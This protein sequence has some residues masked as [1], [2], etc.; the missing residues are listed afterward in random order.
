[1]LL[2]AHHR[3]ASAPFVLVSSLVLANDSCMVGQGVEGHE[4]TGERRFLAVEMMPNAMV[5]GHDMRG[6]RKSSLM[7]FICV[8]S[9]HPRIRHPGPHT[10][11]PRLLNAMRPR[12]NVVTM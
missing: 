1:M 6:I 9:L 4:G 5:N 3:R 10:G 8:R 11:S 12:H 7:L 2:Q